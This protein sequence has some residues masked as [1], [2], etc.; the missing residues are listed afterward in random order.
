MSDISGGHVPSAEEILANAEVSAQQLYELAAT[1][2][3]LRA[4]IAEHPN[5]YPELL[6]WL[7]TQDD[8]EIQAAIHR[9]DQLEETASATAHPGEDAQEPN[10]KSDSAP[11]A[12]RVED[13]GPSG[14]ASEPE[15]ASESEP[16]GEQTAKEIDLLA[17][18]REEESADQPEMSTGQIDERAA[19]SHLFGERDQ[20]ADRDEEAG[21]P[22]GESQPSGEDSQMGDE[23]QAKVA[24]DQA[25]PAPRER[26]EAVGHD[27]GG[28][29]RA[30]EAPTHADNTPATDTAE[31]ALPSDDAPIAGDD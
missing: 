24:A 14:A 26:E 21:E 7:R 8:P 22:E 1:Q 15:V 17:A 5:T 4:A 25:E 3:Q 16:A 27:S 10:A 6:Q 2:P 29:H 23:Q 30:P 11:A 18:H 9:R 31:E 28:A 13:D 12:E 19:A 20:V